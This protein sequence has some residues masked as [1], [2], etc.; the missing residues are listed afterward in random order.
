[1]KLLEKELA[2]IVNSLIRKS[3]STDSKVV[4]ENLNIGEDR[5]N[6]SISCKRLINRP[7]GEMFYLISF[8]EIS[9]A[10]KPTQLKKIESIELSSQY[11]E[12]I[13]ELEKELQYKSESLQATVEELETSNEELQSSN[14]ELIASN[15][16]LQST[17]EELQS[18][19]EELYTVNSEHIRKIEELTEL[20]A[21]M[22]N[23]LKNTRVGNLF[24]DRELNIRKVNEVASRITNVL[25]T[26]RGRPI[27]HLSV[28]HIYDKFIDDVKS[29]IQTLQPVEREIQSQDKYV[30][31]MRIIPYRTA[32]NAINGIIITFVDITMLQ[33]SREL[34]DS[35]RN[36]L[37]HALV[38][39]EMAWWEWD[40]QQNIVITGKGKY[41]MLGY[42]KNEIGTSYQ[43]WTNLIHPED[44]PLTMHAM[45]EYLENKRE[46]YFVEYRIK[47]KSGEYVWYRDKGGI[48]EFTEDGK[49]KKLI[50]IVMN[51]DKEKAINSKYEDKIHSANTELARTDYRYNLLFTSM[52]QGV[53][54]QDKT[55]K[56]IDINPAAVSILGVNPALASQMD[57]NSEE[58]QSLDKNKKPFPG[59][60]HPSMVALSTGQKV[61]NIIMGVYNPKRQCY[62]WIKINAVPIFDEEGKV[63]QVYTV[64]DEID[65]K[66]DSN[67]Q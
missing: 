58:W 61:E 32:E 11:Q 16:E 37:E 65:F 56:I 62:V 47:A 4:I 12:R 14:E 57:S 6:L 55:G 36:R 24:L 10:D 18:V 49:P 25:P 38:M 19:N 40:Y 8:L 15:E 27:Y 52:H 2:I 34:V 45:K 23:L 31:L 53:V 20:N 35:L 3:S 59:D 43:D 30:Y 42:S 63:N 50:G 64:F 41:E 39:G 7:T 51:I 26:D 9:Q 28:K 29:V 66:D 67:A 33:Q 46:I 48:V 5:K 22:D 44:L 60:K 21:D 1:M 13:E 17:N 54:F